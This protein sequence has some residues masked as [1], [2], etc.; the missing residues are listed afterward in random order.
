MPCAH[1][2]RALGSSAL[3]QC[4]VKAQGLCSQGL[5]HAALPSPGSSWKSLLGTY[6]PKKCGFLAER[7]SGEGGFQRGSDAK[8]SEEFF[9]QLYKVIFRKAELA[10]SAAPVFFGGLLPQ[11][12]LPPWPHLRLF[13]CVPLAAQ[14]R[15]VPADQYCTSALGRDRHPGAAV[16]L[17]G[18]AAPAGFARERETGSTGNWPP[19]PG[20]IGLWALLAARASGTR[21][22]TNVVTAYQGIVVWITAKSQNEQIPV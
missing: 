9:L 12:S 20:G 8:T 2:V 6:F 17:P 4:R 15:V 1:H 18:S 10:G 3:W 13:P 19:F 16:F 7:C 5:P 11:M 21:R 14:A 22:F